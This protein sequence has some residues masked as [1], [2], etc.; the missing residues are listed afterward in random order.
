MAPVYRFLLRS[1]GARL[2]GE[3]APDPK[4][5]RRMAFDT[6]SQTIDLGASPVEL[7]RVLRAYVEDVP[8]RVVETIAERKELVGATGQLNPYGAI[9]RMVCA[10]VARA[11]YGAR[12][13]WFQYPDWW[14][15]SRT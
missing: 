4:A 7:E 6:V 15:V 14:E 12:L 11:S 10:M 1:R 8:P 3:T 9:A 5:A 13:N 2:R